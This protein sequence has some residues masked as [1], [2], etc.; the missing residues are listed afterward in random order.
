MHRPR[1]T[2]RPA[3]LLALNLA[4][5]AV[6]ISLLAGC[7]AVMAEFNPNQTTMGV[8]TATATPATTATPTA[9]A[10]D[11]D[12]ELLD[13]DTARLALV[14]WAPEHLVPS[15]ETPGGLELT[16]QIAAFEETHPG[17]PVE[18]YAKKISGAGSIMSY[19]HTAP[20]VAPA[21]LPD[22]VLLNHES[23]ITAAREH[24]IAPIGDLLDDDIAAGMYPVAVELGTVDDQ[25]V[26]LPYVLE[27]QHAIYRQVL[28]EAPPNSFEQVL[29]SPV[30]FTFPAGARG[31]VN[32][33][34]L[35]QYI[36]AAGSLTDEDGSPTIDA[37]ALREVLTF[38]ED[39]Y[40]A[41]VV[42]PVLFQIVD[43]Q[44]TWIAYRDRGV[45]LAVV[46]S[47]LYLAGREEVRSTTGLSW[48]PTPQGQAFTLATGWS[49]AIVTADP[50]RQARAVALIEHLM[51]PIQQGVFTEAASWLP[52][53]RAALTVWGSGDRYASFGNTL[54]TNAAPFPD[55]ALLTATGPAIQGALEDVL[56]NNV[57][58]V[59]AANTAAQQV[60]TVLRRC[61]R[62]VL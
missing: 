62:G 8:P 29:A 20:P 36:A 6:L 59:Q 48:I 55:P 57:Q 16:D 52:S 39:A 14:V 34:L 17:I 32:Q 46:T 28:F 25:L 37:D 31:T 53:N 40:E 33:T 22:L 23:L 18:F 38:Y 60:N 54:L 45:G 51:D 7:D 44:E 4:R 30:P 27:V 2:A 24:L 35:L 58:P 11:N 19:L 26:G 61:S 1:S 10:P 9:S 49:W 43:P 21:V 42:D 13:G 15:S 47:T 12:N 50:E 5:G 3:P 56:L 41:G